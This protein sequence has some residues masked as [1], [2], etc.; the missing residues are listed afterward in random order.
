MSGEP[1]GGDALAQLRQQARQLVA[2]VAGPLRRLSMRSGDA[3][4]EIEWHATWPGS[5]AP[6][7]TGPVPLAVP[8]PPADTEGR[9]VVVSPIVGTFY[10]APEPGAAPF[11]EVGDA[12]EAGQVM[13]IAEAMKLMNH[14]TAEQAGK[15]A[16]V[17]VGDGEPVE[18]EQA[19]I[20]LIPA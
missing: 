7:T 2:E 18:F 13:G 9:I 10:R 12:V 5:T 4:V 6:D 8:E 20:A 14:I 11:V 1:A 16:E 17:R 15:V 19:L 3:V